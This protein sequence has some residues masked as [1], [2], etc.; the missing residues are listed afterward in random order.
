MR[1]A[2]IYD[3]LIIAIGAGLVIPSIPGVELKNIVTL[4]T[5]ADAEVIIFKK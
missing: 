1:I 3:K 5:L 2:V 4:K